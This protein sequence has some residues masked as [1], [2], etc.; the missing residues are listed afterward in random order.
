[1]NRLKFDELFLYQLMFAEI[2]GDRE[3]KLAQSIPIEE[4]GLKTFVKN[5]PFPLTNA[6]RRAGWDIVKDMAKEEPM[7]RLLEGDVGSG[8]TAVAGLVIDHVA[9][10]GYTAVYLA[11]TEIL[12]LQQHAS[13]QKWIKKPVALM[14]SGQNRLGEEKVRR[15]D[16]L[17]AIKEGKVPVIAGT[18]ALF[19]EG[20][21]IPDLALVVI[22]E[23]HR[24]GVEQRHSLLNRHPAPHL[25][26]MTATPIPRSLMLTLY[27]DLD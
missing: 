21:E 4:E 27:G 6:Q 13:L 2:R 18:H 19:E 8:K 24:F 9:R 25:L 12:A 5:L 17:K 3:Q 14:T 7:N 10:A 23:Q 15:N 22:D 20:I 11:P 26:S 16:L 1:M